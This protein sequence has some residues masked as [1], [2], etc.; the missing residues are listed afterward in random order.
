MRLSQKMA[1]VIRAC[2]YVQKDKE[3]TFHRYAYA[4]A[5][6]VVDKVNA[7]LADNEIATYPSYEVLADIEVPTKQGTQRMVT[8]RVKIR[9][10]SEDESAEIEG[11]GSGMDGGD[12]AVMK[13]Q[14]AAIKYAWLGALCISVG[15]DP[16]DDEATDKAVASQPKRAPQEQQ[17]RTAQ[18]RPKVEPL[19]DE[20]IDEMIV[21]IGSVESAEEYEPLREKVMQLWPRMTGARRK[22]VG[23]LMKRTAERIGV[24]AARKAS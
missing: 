19:A 11:L 2:S 16:E 14:T 7:A 5:A 23:E 8:L 15:D 18:E 24:S 10:V 20:T 6:A 17:K 1:R 12:K 3:N 9:I 13:A 21:V 4:S 22:S